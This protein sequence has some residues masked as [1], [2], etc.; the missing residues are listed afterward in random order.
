[1]TNLPIYATFEKPLS[2][3]LD[4]DESYE[5]NVTMKLK[6]KHLSK[7]IYNT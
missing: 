2:L 6:L 4:I 7:K 5:E 1:M 3:K